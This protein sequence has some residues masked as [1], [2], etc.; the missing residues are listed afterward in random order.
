MVT[1]DEPI[2]SADGHMQ[3]DAKRI[4]A[5]AL[6]TVIS[7]LDNT[8]DEV[9]R[10]SVASGNTSSETMPLTI[11]V[12]VDASGREH[13]PAVLPLEQVV[14]AAVSGTTGSGKSY[15]ARVIVE[16][17]MQVPD[18]GVL[19]LDPRSQ[20]AGLLVAEDRPEM[21]SRYAA[22]GMDAAE[23]HGFDCA[24]HAP[25]MAEAPLPGDLSALAS[26]RT[27]VSLKG[28][29]DAERC[30]QAAAV[31]ENVFDALE[32]S[33]ES[34][35]PRLMIVIDEAHL[36]TKKR[37][38]DEDAAASAGHAEAAVDRFVREGR[39]FGAVMVLLSQSMKDFSRDLASVRQM[40]STKA[41]LRNADNEID[42]AATVLGDGKQLVNLP[43]G[44]ALIHN[45]AWGVSRVRVRPPWS[46]VFQL[47]DSRLHALLVRPKLKSKQTVS[48]AART[49]LRAIRDRCLAAG[50]IN[51]TQAAEAGGITSK[52]RLQSLVDE[53]VNARLL[54]SRKLPERGSPRLI[55]PTSLSPPRTKS[56]ADADESGHDRT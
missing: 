54:T 55:Q 29:S 22:F 19:V 23:A 26:G 27:V 10:R 46:K 37:I 17:A 42:Y 38:V 21:L 34:E 43:T 36:F 12:L 7:R 52:R 16:E 31:L 2:L 50:P 20:F 15:L 28:L 56:P 44:V 32:R 30:E 35:R 48:S 33:G 5:R 45:A 14:H 4:G 11:G 13:G 3:A 41:F 9:Q 1:P 24:Y 25:A 53:L 18:L 49:L 39:K 6:S 40:T 8:E 47:D 51:M